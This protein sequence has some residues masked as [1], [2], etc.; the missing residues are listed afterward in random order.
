M[1][2]KSM[3]R[4]IS[5]GSLFPRSQSGVTWPALFWHL[6][7]AGHGSKPVVE[8]SCWPCG[9]LEGEVGQASSS[10]FK[11]MS[12]LA[13]SPQPHQCHQLETSI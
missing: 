10:P 8:L 1:L 12:L 7:E 4:K 2:E 6:G 3:Q 11:A 13:R 5:F 9:F